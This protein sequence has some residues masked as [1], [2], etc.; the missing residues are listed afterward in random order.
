MSQMMHDKSGGGSDLRKFLS[1]NLA[2]WHSF[3]Q[4]TKMIRKGFA[5]TIRARL[6][7]E[8]SMHMEYT[9]RAYPSFRTEL[10]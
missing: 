4:A 10:E 5:N 6:S 2:Y 3:K 8:A 9:A 1:C 7:Q